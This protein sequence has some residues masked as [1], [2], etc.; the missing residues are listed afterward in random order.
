MTEREKLIQEHIEL[1][2][3]ARAEH[4]KEAKAVMCGILAGA[5]HRR[6]VGIRLASLKEAK[7]TI[8]GKQQ[9]L[10]PHGGWEPLFTSKRTGKCDTPA[11]FEFSSKTAARYIDFASKHPEPIMALTDILREAGAM[12]L[13]AGEIEEQ[14]RIPGSQ[15]PTPPTSPWIVYISKTREEIGKLTEKVPLEK[16]DQARRDLV[17]QHLK[18]LVEIYQAL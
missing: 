3:A 18:P 15:N 17:R 11:S 1:I 12:L 5:N 7:I 16:W 14:K 6:E 2:N 13:D 4:A 10:V 9:P 8:D